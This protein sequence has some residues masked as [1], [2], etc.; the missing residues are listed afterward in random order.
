MKSLIITMFVKYNCDRREIIRKIIDYYKCKIAVSDSNVNKEHNFRN[1][2]NHCISK[3]S[4]NANIK[5]K[6]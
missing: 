4:M 6:L 5:N 1:V 2:V 3:Y